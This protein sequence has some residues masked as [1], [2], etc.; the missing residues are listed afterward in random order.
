MT[1]KAV[2]LPAPFEPMSPTVSPFATV[3]FRSA[4]AT[5][6]PKVS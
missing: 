1:L 4:M 2:V 5:S 6:P 3:K